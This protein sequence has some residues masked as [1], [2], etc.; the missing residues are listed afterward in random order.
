VGTAQP[1][2]PRGRGLPR[3][4]PE[5]DET[6]LRDVVV[7]GAGSRGSRRR[8]TPLRKAWTCWCSRPPGGQAGSSSKI[9]NY[10]GFP[11]GISGQ[12]LAGRAYTRAEKFGAE[13]LIA[14]GAA[15]L[16]CRRT[17]YTI[18][19]ADGGQV[20]TRSVIIASGA[21]YRR[22]LC[23]NLTRFEGA[24]VYYGATH[25]EAQL[26]IGEEV[27][28]VGGGN[29]AGQAAMF[30]SLLSRHVHMLVRGAGLLQTMSRYLVQR[31]EESRRSR[32]GLERRSSTSAARVRSSAFGGTTPIAARWKNGRFATSSS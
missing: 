10:L 20:R 16:D 21:R 24:G 15:R 27:I 9:E 31:I 7:V 30:L 17:P 14:R 26:C 3:L 13:M 12:A 29:F 8:C 2:E 23:D 1:N 19:L 32:F 18:E 6:V 5:I 25:I 4:N 11:T 22:P 28:V